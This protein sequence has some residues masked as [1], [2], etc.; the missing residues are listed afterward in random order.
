MEV[1]QS[2]D[3]RSANRRA[4]NTENLT[5]VGVQCGENTRSILTVLRSLLELFKSEIINYTKCL[6]ALGTIQFS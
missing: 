3:S 5:G 6:C 4:V 1:L 2:R